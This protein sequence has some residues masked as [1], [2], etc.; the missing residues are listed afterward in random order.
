MPMTVRI[1]PLSLALLALAAAWVWPVPAW[2][3]WPFAAHM[4][5]H[6]SLVALAAPLVA[7]AVA[8]GPLDPVRWRRP[9]SAL[10]A[11][12]VEGVVVWVFHAPAFHAAAR[13]NPVVW[14]VEQG[15]FLSCAV[16]LWIAALGG[17]AALR[18]RRAVGGIAALLLTS[19]HMTLL[20][21][22]VALAP[23][24]LYVHAHGAAAQGA[25]IDQQLGGSIMAVV[26]GAA[27]LAGGLFLVA[28][29]VRGPRDS[30]E[31]VET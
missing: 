20:G 27:Y 14:I 23:R 15:G 9:P 29:L 8:G 21:A 6:V 22:L 4:A 28:D 19:M 30:T 10:G 11:S 2:D 26:G 31:R 17:G 5:A 13:S 24:E 18:R 25:T 7:L 3:G 1:A 16:T 12:L